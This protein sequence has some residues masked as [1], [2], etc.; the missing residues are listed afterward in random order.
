MNQFQKFGVIGGGA[1]GTALAAA[2]I[3]AGRDVLLWAREENVVESINISHENKVFLKGVALDPALRA[4]NVL[5]DMAACDAYLWVAPVQYSASLCQQLKDAIKDGQKA[6]VILCSKGIERGSFRFPFEIIEEALPDH[7]VAVLSGPSFAI[8]VARNQP[9][10]V[11]LAARDEALA[12]ALCRAIGSVTFRPYMSGDVV[13]VS[14]GGAIKNVLAVATGI[15]TGCG[16]GE[17]ARAALIT[18]GLVEMMRFGQALGAKRETL[19]GLSGQGD[20]VLTCSSTQ[21]R[22]M[23]LGVAL[24]QGKSLDEILASRNSVAEGVPTAAAAAQVARD[25]GVEM[26]I[27]EAVDAVLNQGAKV[28]DS[29]AALLSRPFKA[30]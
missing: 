22:N 4:T 10:A 20:L 25:K 18:R 5:K 6:P 8:E 7:P 1:W 14:L 21:S 15:A 28:E 23:S 16:M 3:R 13:G 2:L 26:P 17:N 9:T 11:T 29:I 30:E 19:M 12:M 24:G 27:V